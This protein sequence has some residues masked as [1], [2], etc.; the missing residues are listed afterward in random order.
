MPMIVNN[1]SVDR[2]V[3]KNIRTNGDPEIVGEGGIEK[4]E[5]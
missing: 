5:Q 3:V 2:L 1:G 4:I